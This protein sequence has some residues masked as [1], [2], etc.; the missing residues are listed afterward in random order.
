VKSVHFQKQI[1][2]KSM[3][4]EAGHP[5]GPVS[6]PAMKKNEKNPL[7]V[8][9]RA[10]KKRVVIGDNRCLPDRTTTRPY[11]YRGQAFEDSLQC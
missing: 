8:D 11:W 9:L 6:Q 5:R 4:M 7:L 10:K 3:G 2:G 1:E